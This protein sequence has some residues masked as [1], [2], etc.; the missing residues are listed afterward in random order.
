MAATPRSITA[1]Y[2][3]F[4]NGESAASLT[5][6]PTCD[7]AATSSSAVGNYASTCSGAVDPNYSI[8]Y[9]NG[10]VA[11]GAAQLVITASSSSTTYGSDPSA[12][13]ASYEGFVNGDTAASLTTPPTCTTTD[14]ASSPAGR[15]PTSCSGAV[16]P[17]Y[18]ITYSNGSVEVDPAPLTITASSVCP[19]T[20]HRHL[21]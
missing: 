20:A 14:T 17:N 19:P 8:T 1:S 18:A 3:G 6:Q 9:T 11:V 2:A 13:T 10:T 4:V 12:V 5:T 16:D 21:R 15:Y 7:T